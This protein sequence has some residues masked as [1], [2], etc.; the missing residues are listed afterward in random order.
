MEKM[1]KNVFSVET[2]AE[3]AWLNVEIKDYSELDEIAMRVVS[4]DCPEFLLPI[5]MAEKNGISSLRYRLISGMAL[6]YNLRRNMNKSAFLDFAL[7]LMAP[8]TSAA[9]ATTTAT[10]LSS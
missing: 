1:E 4:Q 10:A 8:F 7:K 3:A 5:H 6:A 9:G 2:S